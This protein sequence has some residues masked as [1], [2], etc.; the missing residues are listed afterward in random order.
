MGFLNFE[1]NGRSGNARTGILELKNCKVETPEL[2]VVATKA[3]IKGISLDELIE[4]GI[5][6]II[7]NT[8][9]LML[10]PGADRIAD[11]GGLHSFMGGF[12][13]AVVTDSGGLQE[14]ASYLRIP[15]LTIRK[16]TERPV[17]ESMGTNKVIGYDI[18]KLHESIDKI[19]SG[20]WKKGED[21]PLWDG[22]STKRILDFLDIPYF[23][24]VNELHAR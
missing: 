12:R 14:E 11:L 4:I 7:C 2:M 9:H 13:G 17:T 23:K 20:D 5:Q 24:Q 15:C 21:I 16:N 8:Y 22:N 6:M 1:I 19:L 10:K 18:K 3:S